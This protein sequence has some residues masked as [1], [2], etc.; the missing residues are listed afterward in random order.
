MWIVAAK[1]RFSQPRFA[2]N[3]SARPRFGNGMMPSICA[4]ESPASP[5][6]CIEA[7]SCKPSWVIPEPGLRQ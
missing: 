5:I 2:A 3:S 4:G 1:R 6:A 7:F